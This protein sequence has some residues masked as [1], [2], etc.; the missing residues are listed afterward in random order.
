MRK[1]LLIAIT[2]ALLATPAMSRVR[3]I[4]TDTIIPER[5]VVKSSLFGITLLNNL[6]TYLSN[7]NHKGLGI[8]FSH[9]NFRDARTGNYR[10]KYQTLFNATLGYATLGNNIQYT[11]LISQSWSGYHPFKVAKGLTLLAGAQIQFEGGA[12]YNP[13]NGN[14]PAAAKLRTALAATGM[15]IYHF[16]VL[17]SEWIARYQVDIPLAGVMFAPEFGQSYYEIFGLGHAKGIIS[18]T[19]PGNNPSWRHTLSLDI[20]MRIKRHSTTLRISY[21]ADIYQS[22]INSIDCHIYRHTFALGFARTIFKIK[23]EN[24]MNNHSPY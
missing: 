4:V 19:H 5:I 14:N 15:V 13:A 7:Y 11:A 12:L 21:T 8:N 23:R 20:P 24:R 16:P 3:H 10:W 6:D 2:L 18:F 17:R 22:R 1:A 9:E